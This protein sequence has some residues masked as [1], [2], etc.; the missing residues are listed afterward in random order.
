MEGYIY[1]LTNESMPN[2]LKIGKTT[3][4]TFTR[5]TELSNSTG[6]PTPF[7]LAFQQ[8]F[9]DCHTAESV[10][11]KTLELKGERLNNNREFFNSSLESV[12]QL[13]LE[14]KFKENDNLVDRTTNGLTEYKGK[15][16]LSQG[17]AQYLGIGE[18]IQDYEE[19]LKTLK[20][21]SN[22]GNQNANR[23]LSMLYYKGD[24]T[25]KNERMT[26]DYLKKGMNAGDVGSTALL[27]L[28]SL[29]S[30]KYANKENCKKYWKLFL[31]GLQTE[32]ITDELLIYLYELICLEV[33]EYGQISLQTKNVIK[34][35][36]IN[37]IDYIKTRILRTKDSELNKCN[38]PILFQEVFVDDLD[39][40]RYIEIKVEN[41]TQFNNEKFYR[42][43]SDELSN[44]ELQ[45]I[46]IDELQE[47]MVNGITEEYYCFKYIQSN[48]KRY[49]K[50]SDI[51]DY[52]SRH[53]YVEVYKTSDIKYLEYILNTLLSEPILSV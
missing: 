45:T 10:I 40:I 41:F 25:K 52:L 8:Y 19:A 32:E 38:Y 26:F 9:K 37:L 13:I 43:K 30:K 5:I 36:N 12:I 53:N 34:E 33:N 18:T 15:E 22:Y 39:D 2:L 48:S 11:H 24:G 3:R 29:H 27:A 47:L 50:K 21:A 51:A 20:L 23:W 44:Q 49:V 6:V 42:N 31:N 16:L 4:D 14:L 35:K 1:V 28:L 17:I 46:N 7:V